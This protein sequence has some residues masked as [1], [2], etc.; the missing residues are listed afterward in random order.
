MIKNRLTT[1]PEQS[2]AELEVSLDDLS[3]AYN[4]IIAGKEGKQLSAL[5]F[6]SKHV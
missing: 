2:E 6:F 4:T 5:H 3:H 1:S